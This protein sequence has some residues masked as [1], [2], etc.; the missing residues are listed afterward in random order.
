MND[1]PTYDELVAL[2]RQAP[3][4]QMIED[5]RYWDWR[6]RLEELLARVDEPPL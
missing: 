4:R 5:Q 2:L 1:R 6:K 3:P